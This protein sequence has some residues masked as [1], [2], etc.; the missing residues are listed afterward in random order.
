MAE[1]N[2]QLEAKNIIMSEGRINIID[3]IPIKD[4]TDLPELGSWVLPKMRQFMG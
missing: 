3:A 2:R 1:I 4:T